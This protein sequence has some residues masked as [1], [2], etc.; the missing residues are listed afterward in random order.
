MITLSEAI[1]LVL[2]HSSNPLGE[3]L[4]RVDHTLRNHILAEDVFAQSDIPA[5]RTTNVDGY[6]VVAGS[7][8]EGVYKVDKAANGMVPGEV[9]RVNTGGP[10]P[11]G[12]DAVVMVED[13]E[14]KTSK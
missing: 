6:A 4:H 13:T 11:D 9:V 2:R 10:L 12:A 5:T 7:T 3:V 8:P 1:S 14:L